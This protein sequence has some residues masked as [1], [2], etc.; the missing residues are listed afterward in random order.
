M[1]LSLKGVSH[2]L[3]NRLWK[4]T[5]Y[6]VFGDAQSLGQCARRGVASGF[7]AELVFLVDLDSQL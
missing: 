3:S 5:L 1:T 2:F 7:V 6:A 4:A